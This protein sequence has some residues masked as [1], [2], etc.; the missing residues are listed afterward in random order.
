ML[1]LIAIILILVPIIYC[2]IYFIYKHIIIRRRALIEEY[3]KSWVVITGGSAGIGEKLAYELAA[4]GFDI[5][6]IGSKN[7]LN[8][9]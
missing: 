7:S 9:L 3:G 2:E 1:G 5:C 8:M 6:I 4:E